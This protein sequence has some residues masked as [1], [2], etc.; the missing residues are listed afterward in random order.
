M[1]TIPKQRKASGSSSLLSLASNDVSEMMLP[2]F[3]SQDNGS[4]PELIE[5]SFRL[6]RLSDHKI[7]YNLKIK[8]YESQ[9]SKREFSHDVNMSIKDIHKSHRSSRSSSVPVLSPRASKEPEPQYISITGAD[10]AERKS[11]KVVARAIAQIRRSGNIVRMHFRDEHSLNATLREIVNQV[12]RQLD[13]EGTTPDV[14]LLSENP[15][16]ARPNTT[17]HYDN[18]PN[19]RLSDMV[20]DPS[21]ELHVAVDFSFE[22]A[23]AK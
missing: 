18:L 19:W 12:I 14:Y 22:L 11:G 6:Q 5:H 4:K 15:H 17:L 20:V 10:A 23:K 16:L 21:K 1:C 8:W 9:A 7:L 3:L 13:A 2:P